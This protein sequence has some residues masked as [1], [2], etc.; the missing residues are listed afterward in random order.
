[1]TRPRKNQIVVNLTSLG[2]KTVDA[3]SRSDGAV[4]VWDA[5]NDQYVH[6][7]PQAIPNKFEDLLEKPNSLEGYGIQNAWDKTSIGDP[8]T[9][10][11]ALFESVLV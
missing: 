3:P 6:E 4:L 7:P 8:A 11:V 10:Y 5:E 9:N 2:G 1:M